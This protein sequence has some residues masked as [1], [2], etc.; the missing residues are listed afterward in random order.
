[1][2]CRDNETQREVTTHS[3]I[4]KYYFHN[5]ISVVSKLFV[6]NVDPKMTITYLNDQQDQLLNPAR[7]C[8]C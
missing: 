3:E 1:M 2:R 4:T 8:T 7:M 6:Q 5:F